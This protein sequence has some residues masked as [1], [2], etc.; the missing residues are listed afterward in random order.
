MSL[1]HSP[2]IV[3][4][5]LVFCVEAASVRSYPRTGTTWYDLARTANGAMQ[6]MDASNFSEDK[7]GVLNFDG[8]NESVN[9]NISPQDLVGQGSA[10]TISAWFNVDI[11]GQCIIIGNGTSGR[12]YIET[13]NGPY[14]YTVH[15]GFGDTNNAATGSAFIETGRWYNYTAVFDGTYAKEYLNGVS[16]NHSSNLGAR[17]YSGT[18]RIGTWQGSNFMFNGK[19]G[20]IYVYNR[21]LSAGEVLQNYNAIKG[22]FK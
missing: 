7:R 19:I 12:F 6:N 10:A 14:G 2:L 13:Y 16:T 17:A 5:G 8:T 11:V 22:R 18:M 20:N 1:S 9:L 21:G 15:W 4:D 3:R